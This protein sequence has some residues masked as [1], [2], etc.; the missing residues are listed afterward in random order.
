VRAALPRGGRAPQHGRGTSRALRPRRS[1]V[2]RSPG[3]PPAV[4]LASGQS[5]A[6]IEGIRG[7][8]TGDSAVARASGTARPAAEPQTRVHRR[9]GAPSVRTAGRLPTARLQRESYATAAQ[10]P[11][12]RPRREAK[13]APRTAERP[14]SAERRRL[15]EQRRLTERRR[16]AERRSQVARRPPRVAARRPVVTERRPR[17]AERWLRDPERASR[18]HRSVNEAPARLSA[19]A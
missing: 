13:R 9:W 3:R 1:M 17:A 2:R 10:L 7:R 19:R 6:S 4:S 11:V 14:Q 15:T 8:G 12:E 18:S 5:R 16:L